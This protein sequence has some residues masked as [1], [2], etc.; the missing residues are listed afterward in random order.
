MVRFLILS[1]VLFLSLGCSTNNRKVD[2]DYIKVIYSGYGNSGYTYFEPIRD[3]LICQMIY[4][5]DN[6]SHETL[7]GR[8]ANSKLLDTFIHTIRTLKQYKHGSIIMPVS[9]GTFYCGPSLY[10]EF[11]DK[12]GIHFYSYVFGINDTLDH[13]IHFYENLQTLSWDKQKVK[14]ELVDLNSEKK[15]ANSKMLPTF[16]KGT[17]YTALPCGNGIDATKLYG[18]WRSVSDSISRTKDGYVKLTIQKN[19]VCIF[20]R[21]LNDSTQDSHLGKVSLNNKNNS[22]VFTEYGKEYHYTIMQLCDNCLQYRS[23]DEL[24]TIRFD[25]IH[26]NKEDSQK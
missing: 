14:N 3:S 11:K 13:F 18:S 23:E 26:E 2:F 6:L 10:T 22:L 17:F 4:A 8:I 5:D 15:S 19:G 20:K 12:K 1:A 21:I 7:E 9:D 25:R 24:K 16:K